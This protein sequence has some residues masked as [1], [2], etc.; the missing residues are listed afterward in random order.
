MIETKNG[1]KIITIEIEQYLKL[2]DILHNGDENREGLVVE[3]DYS[4]NAIKKD[5]EAL[6]QT[7]HNIT[8]YSDNVY[9]R[10][11]INI[12][13]RSLRN[14]VEKLE[15]QHNEIIDILNYFI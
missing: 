10:D 7:A 3:C 11:K 6:K 9:L 4:F 13:E 12:I 15:K 8:V 2:D 1:N 14:K 5:L